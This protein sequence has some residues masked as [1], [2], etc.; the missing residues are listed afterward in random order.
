MTQTPTNHSVTQSR[1]HHGHF[2]A[3]PREGPSAADPGSTAALLDGME[4][5]ATALGA[6]STWPMELE[7]AIRTV[8][9]SRL[10]VM[11]YLGE[12][13]VQ[14]YND[15]FL[16]IL[17]N[18]HPDAFG[19]PAARCW[20]EVWQTL[21]PDLNSIQ[22]GRQHSL[23]HE[24]QLLF[25]DRHGYLEETYWTYSYSPVTDADGR[26]LGVF[27]QTTDTGTA[28]I[29]GER[30]LRT[31]HDLGGVPSTSTADPADACRLVLD[32]LARN[33]ADIPFCTVY[34]AQPD[35]PVLVASYGFV[36][37]GPLPPGPD[38]DPLG[39]TQLR[40]AVATGRPLLVTDLRAQLAG[41]FDTTGTLG[42]VQPDAALIMPLNEHG[43]SRL[44]GAIVLGISPYREF[45]ADY[46]SFFEL[47]A[48]QVCIAIT[49]ALAY[50]VERHRAENLA[51]LDLAKTRFFQNISHEL[52]TPLT[53]ILGP[54][55]Q[56]LDDPDVILGAGHREG[57]Q[58]AR[59]SA[60]R[61]QRLVD[62]L[63]EVARNEANRLH[64]QIEPTDLATLTSDCASMFRSAA[65]SAGLRLVVQTP[66]DAPVVAVDRNIWTHIVLN[67]LS[68]AVKFTDAGSVTV[69]LEITRDRVELAVRDT[70][71]G[72]A[73]QDI[74]FIFERFHQLRTGV[75]SPRDGAGIGLSLV[76]DLVHAH[77]GTVGATSTPGQGTTFTVALPQS[78]TVSGSPRPLDPAAGVAETFL[79]E[80]SHWARVTAEQRRERLAA[81][82]PDPDARRLLLVE[83]DADM[84][85]Y[86]IRLMESDGWRVDA[87][88]DVET[89]LAGT[90][91]PDLVLA[92]VMLP[93]RGG[94]DL[95]RILRA[96]E[97]TAR[98]PVVLLTA[99]A[100][101]ESI[102]E[103]LA[104]GADDYLVKPFVPT[105]LL[106]RVRVHAELHR[107][108]ELTLTD[109]QERSRNLQIAV[110]TNRQIGT[111]VG[112]LMAEHKINSDEA[113]ELLTT[114]SHTLR[115]KLRDIA[116]EVTTTGE[117]PR[118]T[119]RM[120][121][122]RRN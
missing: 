86:L 47:T 69:T 115:R 28:E 120:S 92:D 25:I 89:A 14:I 4:W 12:E 35:E 7:A 114:A 45:D 110:A 44:V 77:G 48:D 37:G 10:P 11:L 62:G 84:R 111:A 83:D 102:T 106:A 63:L 13:F 76:A 67:L 96:A 52:R 6:R 29:L 19:R 121:Q 27:G 117:L 80:A 119:R 90:E 88:A 85:A 79:S 81:G 26:V 78:T 93:G 1:P 95:L 43:Q 15:A 103:G 42:D 64:P 98:I 71:R 72:I 75:D 68:N 8:L 58:A 112:I 9:A 109:E 65:E 70:G 59:R 36:P 113:F 41:A 105:E 61:L 3:A 100:G 31:L 33:R 101:T 57:L 104:L 99:R 87:F 91:S 94:L 55:L 24:R 20:P 17:G 73:E 122:G 82:E 2:A 38:T 39:M 30:R 51:D 108:R 46:R 18:K 54:V 116:A 74:P 49:D 34:L 60:L 22:T 23:L 56:V 97:A 66:S 5:S 21:G 40:T 50:E 16:P 53:L 32:A 107:V 118:P